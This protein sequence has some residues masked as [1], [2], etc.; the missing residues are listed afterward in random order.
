MNPA[1]AFVYIIAMSRLSLV[2]LCLAAASAPAFAQDNALASCAV[3]DSVA[4]RGNSSVDENAIRGD[5]GLIAG[6]NLNFR[7]VQR[8]IR[9]LFATGQFDDV[10][11]ECNPA[12]GAGAKTILAISVRERPVLS[13]IRID[14]VDRV[15]EKSVRDRIEIPEARPLNPALVTRAVERIDSLYEANGYYLARVRPETTMV[16]AQ[17]RLTFKVEEGRRL[18]VSGIRI[19]GNEKISDRAIVKAMKTRPEGFLWFRKGAF[20]E[21]KYAG[22]LGDGLPALYGSRG[23]I[24]FQVVR[25]TMIVD[26]ENGKALLEITVSEGPQYRVGEFN[27][28]GNRR[29]STDEVVR[30][31]PFTDYTRSI[32]SRVTDVIRG[33][34]ATPEG[35]FDR[36]RWDEAFGNLQTA[37][38]NEGYIYADLRP[39]IERRQVSD[40]SQHIVDLRWVI[41][42]KAPAIINRIEIIG[43][44][45]TVESCIRD[46]LTIIPGDVYNQ[47]RIIQSWQSV[48]NMGFFEAPVQP[49]D[50][51]QA[52]EQ[53]DIDL[54]FNVKERRTGN[55]NFGASV[56][57]GL[58]VGGFIGLDQ[59]NLFGRCKRGS[60]Q[61]QFGRYVND[62]NLS[63][64]DPTIRQSRVSG[65]VSVYSSRARYTV[66]DLGRSLRT[67]GS[68]ELG[69][70]LPRSVFG[71]NSRLRLS[72]GGEIVSFGSDGLL[73]ETEDIYGNNSFRSTLGAT[74][75]HDTRGGM[76][77]ATSGGM[78]SLTA[79]FSGG[80]LGGTYNFQRYTAETRAY[81]PLG[82]IG[83][84]GQGSQPMTFVLGLTGRTGVVT[85]NTGPFFFSQEFAL[86]GVQ[87]G[88]QLR[89]YDEFSISPRGY[90]TGT[91]TYSAQRTSFGKAYFTATAELGFRVNQSLYTNLF[92]DVGNV[93]T[94]ARQFDPTRLFRGAGIGVSTVTPLG[95]LGL[96]YGYGFD[97]LDRNGRPAPKW[98]LHFRLGQLF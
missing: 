69:F 20:D 89:G 78:Q 14:G 3:P 58:G 97:R 50:T 18:A 2:L 51:R 34:D 72:Y 21:D 29:F 64:S 45:Y 30:Y 90:I 35:V 38:R 68:V 11:I 12:S 77:F 73:G 67:G 6:A 9:A 41:D 61:W 83:G 27:V 76:P 59:P 1:G 57:Q 74:L 40:T 63:Y 55:I 31:Y 7:D 23:Y 44:D 24:D 93:Y 75:M 39:V 15:S 86:G 43:N 37:Y 19:I 17:V 84:Q 60:L 4:V 46:Q 62:F 25:D 92:Y 95:P 26:R 54:V 32:T 65:T 8:A 13:D 56:G 36:S 49:P 85:G 5:A 88:E 22:D 28:E 16:G 48:G 42:E 33:R 71:Y 91:D 82:Q 53:G 80:P 10:K 52:N 96:D 66:A 94:N 98:Q 79:Q 81:A 70:P 47:D 87:Y